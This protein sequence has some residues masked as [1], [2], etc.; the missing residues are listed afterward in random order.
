[1]TNP[2]FSRKATK[3]EKSFTAVDGSRSVRQSFMIANT[4]M[5][6]TTTR[7]PSTLRPP[8]PRQAQVDIVSVSM[9]DERVTLMVTQGLT[10]RKATS[11]GSTIVVVSTLVKLAFRFVFTLVKKAIM[12]ANNIPTP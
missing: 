1:M 2:T 11:T 7:L 6:V 12:T 8:P 4:R 9:L 10:L 5:S 3:I